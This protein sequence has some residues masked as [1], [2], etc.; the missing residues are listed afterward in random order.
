MFLGR[1]VAGL[2]FRAALLAGAA[3]C[4]PDLHLLERARR[5]LLGASVGLLADYFGGKAVE[6]VIKKVG[7][8][9][10]ILVVVVALG[11]YYAHRRRSHVG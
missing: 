7:L 8:Y 2:R 4:R 3:G 6:Q 11:L 1:W 10:G 5:H 9:G